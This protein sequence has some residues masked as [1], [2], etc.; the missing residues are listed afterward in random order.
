MKVLITYVEAGNGHKVTSQAIADALK[1]QNKDEKI[2]II[3]KNLFEE[4]PKL[5]K[6]QDFLI[7]E[8]KKASISPMHSNI[9]LCAMHLLGSKNTLKLVNGCIYKKIRDIYIEKLKEINP[10]IIVDT[11]Y[12]CVYCAV[13]YRNKF[14]PKCKIITYDPDNNVHGWWDNRVD[15]FVV[16]NEYAYNQALKQGFKETQVKQVPFITRKIISETSETKEFYRNKYN[17]PQ[18]DFV[19]KLA[20]GLYG[21]AKMK[22][23]IYELIKIEKP[24]SIIAIAGKNEELYNELNQLK[25]TLPANIKLFPFPF[26]KEINELICASDIFITKAGPNAVLDSVYLNVP[27]IINYYANTIE[28][29]TK[30]VFIDRYN[31]GLYIPNK[32]KC[33]EYIEQCIDNRDILKDFIENT[34]Q[35]DKTKNGAPEIAKII[36]EECKTKS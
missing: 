4:D 32:I 6:Y 10:D 31:C 9:Q 14:N 26:V 27:V 29:T 12:F 1:E 19:V 25:E 28:K 36:I 20:D 22:S 2:E 13:T 7:K 15:T 18:S 16:N 23:F 24:L 35:F 34:K 3:E 5:K 21:K 8:V 30:K 11:Y 33:R 17:I